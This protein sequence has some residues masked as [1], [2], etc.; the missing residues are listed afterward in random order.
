MGFS[1]KIRTVNLPRSESVRV[2]RHN[3]T[4]YGTTEGLIN[5]PISSESVVNYF[6][7]AFRSPQVVANLPFASTAKNAE[8]SPR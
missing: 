5:K 2:F 1:L 3:L 7:A 6:D 8:F 4:D